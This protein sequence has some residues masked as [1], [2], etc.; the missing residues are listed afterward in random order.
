MSSLFQEMCKLLQIKRISST[1]FKPKMQGKVEKIHFGMIQTMSHEISKYGSD[2]DDFLDHALMVQR[3]TPHTTTKFSHYYLL[4][5]REM[6]T[7][8]GRLVR[9]RWDGRSRFHTHEFRGGSYSCARGKIRGSI[10]GSY[11]A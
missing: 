7:D 1:S 11:E 4:H 10:W 6:V 8:N 3:S 9:P 5:G 2:W